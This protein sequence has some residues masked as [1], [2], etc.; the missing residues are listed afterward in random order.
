[1]SVVSVEPTAAPVCPPLGRDARA[2]LVVLASAFLAVAA[3]LIALAAGAVLIPPAEVL[4]I[5]L[6]GTADH[7]LHGEVILALRLPRVIEGAAIGAA[8]GVTGAAFQGLFRNPLADPG[9]IGIAAGA[10]VG[11]VAFIVAGAGLALTLGIPRHF[12]LPLAASL[13]A[14]ATALL[15]YR[16]G[17]RDGALDIASLLL[18]GIAI[19]AL[20]LALSGF[21]V[22]G[23]DDQELRELTFWSM[24][25]LA[26][27]HWPV[28]ATALPWLVLGVGVL[29]TH[30]HALNALA[31]GEAE[32]FHLGYRVTV[33]KT[34][35]LLAGAISVGVAVALAGVIGFVGLI[36]PHLL[37]LVVGADHR[38]VLPGSAFLGAALV[39]TADLGARLLV[40]PAELPLG[41]LTSLLGG[42]FFLWLLR[43][44]HRWG[45]TA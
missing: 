16:C 30:A 4:R 22:F 37:R 36:V 29:L 34:R 3:A 5:L 33:L 28:L 9:L 43:P 40:L 19:N 31:L 38:Y 44:H 18:A 41:I 24:G 26:R 32:A 27:A 10:A 35:I 23:S 45:P 20:C 7:A 12:G 14:V 2:R 1:M 39:M 13:G 6:G 15:V 8:L 42:P 25:S 17:Q 11:A 21:L